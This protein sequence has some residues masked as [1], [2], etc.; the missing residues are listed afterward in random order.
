MCSENNSWLMKCW[1]SWL[2]LSV[3]IT[4]TRC[5]TGETT[6]RTYSRRGEFQYFHIKTHRHQREDC[7]TECTRL[8]RCSYRW[9]QQ[10]ASKPNKINTGAVQCRVNQRVFTDI[11]FTE[12]KTDA[13]LWKARNSL[14]FVGIIYTYRDYYLYVNICGTSNRLAN[15]NHD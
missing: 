9:W 12:C 8:A 6:Q 14:D 5:R 1:L 3:R 13:S 11:N 10:H 7:S 15:F 2:V 4:F